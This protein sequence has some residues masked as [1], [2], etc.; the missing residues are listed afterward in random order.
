MA[1]LEKVFKFWTKGENMTE[2][3]L[4]T[5]KLPQPEKDDSVRP[6]SGRVSTDRPRGL[7][8]DQ[9]IAKYATAEEKGELEKRIRERRA[10]LPKFIY[11][12]C[13]KCGYREKLLFGDED[14]RPHDRYCFDCNRDRHL[15]GGIMRE[16]TA[17]EIKKYEEDIA[18]H[19]K[20]ESERFFKAA[21]FARNQGRQE[22][23]LDPLTEEEF[24]EE[25]RQNFQ[26]ANRG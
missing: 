4:F 19:E 12:I 1:E 6:G 11:R 2:K 18:A 22:N 24:K 8:I 14:I 23:G 3:K 15:D 10:K 25:Q 16:M 7:S 26:R 21:F 20:R 17:K 5:H 13:Q 9:Y